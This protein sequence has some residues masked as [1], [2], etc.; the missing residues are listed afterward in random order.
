M[1]Y[2]LVCQRAISL[3]LDFWCLV[4]EGGSCKSLLCLLVS[5]FLL[6]LYTAARTKRQWPDMARHSACFLSSSPRAVLASNTKGHF[7]LSTHTQ[8]LELRLTLSDGQI[9][10][11]RV[12]SRPQP[13]NH[14]SFPLLLLLI[15]GIMA[16]GCLGTNDFLL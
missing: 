16:P 15:L 12:P 7:L 2:F 1:Q 9:I 13:G 4:R 14:F 11:A 8:I 6:S 10:Q 5:G 3:Y